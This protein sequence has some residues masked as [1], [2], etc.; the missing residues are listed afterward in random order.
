RPDGPGDEPPVARPGTT[1]A[2]ARPDRTPAVA[3]RAARNG[4]GHGRRPLDHRLA[5]PSARQRPAG[6]RRPQAGAALRARP[7]P[8]P[9]PA[10]AQNGAS[11]GGG[12]TLAGIS[13]PVPA[14]APQPGNVD[15]MLARLQESLD[16]VEGRQVN[17]LA[18][19]EESYESKARRMRA[20]LA[21]VGLDAAKHP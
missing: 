6:R 5:P 1:R 9:C 21:D 10:R 14:P 15:S 7:V 12:F 17:T 11:S 13:K 4:H 8:H 3:A 2:K 16:R 18:S 20:V 19:L